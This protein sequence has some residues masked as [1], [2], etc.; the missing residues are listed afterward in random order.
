MR[1]FFLWLASSLAT[2][3]F[4]CVFRSRCFL[5]SWLS[6]LHCV[7][8]SH[9]HCLFTSPKILCLPPFVGYY[10][11]SPMQLSGMNFLKILLSPQAL[12]RGSAGFSG[13]PVLSPAGRSMLLSTV[14]FTVHMRRGPL[15]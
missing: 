10:K 12:C 9:T 15:S 2:P 8:E 14:T 13:G 3:S 5:L 11:S 6:A 1:F 7:L 4:V